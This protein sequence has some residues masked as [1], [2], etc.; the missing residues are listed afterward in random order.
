MNV[1][2]GDLVTVG[3]AKMGVYMVIDADLVWRENPECVLL[4]S[5]EGWLAPMGKKF[6]CPLSELNQEEHY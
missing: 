2:V 4:Y 6:L 1:S 5:D 3:P